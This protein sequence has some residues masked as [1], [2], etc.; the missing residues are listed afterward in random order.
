MHSAEEHHS[1]SESSVSGSEKGKAHRRRGRPGGSP[2]KVS[3]EQLQTA[4]CTKRICTGVYMAF[5]ALSTLV[6][7]LY[8]TRV[9]SFAPPDPGSTRPSRCER[10][11]RAHSLTALTHFTSSLGSSS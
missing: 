7:G 1:E 3:C 6:P 4:D 11:Q 5:L 8:A 10:A 9:P 2:S